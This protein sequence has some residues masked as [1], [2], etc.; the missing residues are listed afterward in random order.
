MAKFDIAIPHVLAWEGGYA[1]HPSD[2][3]GETM[4]GITDRLDGK[5]DGM[6][7]VDGDG[8]GDVNVKDLTEEQAKRIYKTR[9]W[10]RM[11]GDK[12]ESQLIANILLDG[13]VNCGANGIRIIQRVLN[14]KDDGIVGP[15]TLTAINGADEL[16]LYN[17][18]KDG[19]IKYYEDLVD[20]KPQLN[21]FLK[22]WLNRIN[23]FPD[24]I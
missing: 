9:F 8:I 24:L 10:D 5:I 21:V 20:R 4:R 2:P 15:K 18:Y 11:Q 6:I 23:S 1:N 12:I 14:Q 3:G 16:L 7:D 19:R 17:R 13:Y 22:G